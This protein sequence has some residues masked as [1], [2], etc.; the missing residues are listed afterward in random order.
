MAT[1]PVKRNKRRAAG[2]G[3]GKTE[4]AESMLTHSEI[5]LIETED[6]QRYFCMMLHPRPYYLLKVIT[7]RAEYKHRRWVERYNKWRASRNEPPYQEIEGE[8]GIL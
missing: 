6:G 7:A 4:K 5:K 3:A 1:E 8:V 2:H